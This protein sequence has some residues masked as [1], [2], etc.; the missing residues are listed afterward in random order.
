[1]AKNVEQAQYRL[2]HLATGRLVIDQDINYNGV[3]LKTLGLSPHI[4][5]RNLEK[6]S[7]RH[8]ELAKKDLEQFDTDLNLTV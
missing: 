2:R 1:M 5:A 8:V 7:D 3:Q 6:L 4:I